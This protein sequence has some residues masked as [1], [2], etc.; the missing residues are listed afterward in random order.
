MSE[1]PRGETNSA[2]PER[3][4][5]REIGMPRPSP[6]AARQETTLSVCG[7]PVEAR[8]GP[9]V[10]LVETFGLVFEAL[11]REL[12]VVGREFNRENEQGKGGDTEILSTE[13]LRRLDRCNVG[14]DAKKQ[15]EDVLDA[16]FRV[17]IL[18]TG[19]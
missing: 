13:R 11:V 19:K 4:L 18:E 5:A 17:D 3:L 12:L 2:Y 9:L 15:E 14:G 7:R 1:R 16:G 6:E 8:A 10:G